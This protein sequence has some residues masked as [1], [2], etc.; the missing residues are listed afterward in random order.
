MCCER[1][2]SVTSNGFE[3]CCET[4]R[5]YGEVQP[6]HP[7][8]PWFPPLA[9]C[10]APNRLQNRI[11]ILAQDCIHSI[12]SAYFGDVYAPVTAA[13]GRTNLRSATRGDLVI[14]RTRTKLD[15][16]SFCISVPT[17]WN[18]LPD[19]LKHFAT[20]LN[21]FEKNWKHTCLGKPTHQP[22]RTIEEWTYLLSY[23]LTY[24]KSNCFYCFM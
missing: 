6:R 21:I 13:S 8:P 2:R 1:R 12:G 23:L 3:R 16:W 17:V 10:T 15:K 20:S 18:S 19:S 9:P 24:Y 5:W 7:Y 22:L 14:P 4:R 11:A